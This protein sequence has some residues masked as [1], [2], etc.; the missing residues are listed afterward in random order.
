[1]NCNAEA[2]YSGR[3]WD[4]HSECIKSEWHV[5]STCPWGDSA[6]IVII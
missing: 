3:D 1:M 4:L 6:A 5:P 2:A